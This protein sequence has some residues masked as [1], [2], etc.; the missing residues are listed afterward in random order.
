[1]AL[2]ATSSSLGAALAVRQ[3]LSQADFATKALSQTAQQQDAAV[4]TLLA[5]GGGTAGGNV[6]PT[7]GQNLNIVV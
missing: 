2:D 1:M 5:A 7:R 3:G 6:T 4:A